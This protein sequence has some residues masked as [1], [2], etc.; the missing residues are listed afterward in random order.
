[1]SP[2]NSGRYEWLPFQGIVYGR[3]PLLFVQTRCGRFNFRHTCFQVCRTFRRR[4]TVVAVFREV[5]VKT[6]TAWGILSF[7]FFPF[8]SIGRMVFELWEKP[9]ED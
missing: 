3:Q 1:M 5:S 2:I 8:Y 7:H 6:D 9:Q 4:A